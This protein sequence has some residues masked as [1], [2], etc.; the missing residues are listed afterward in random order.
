MPLNSLDITEMI[1]EENRNDLSDFSNTGNV[2]SY[3]II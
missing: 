3:P 2:S 1:I